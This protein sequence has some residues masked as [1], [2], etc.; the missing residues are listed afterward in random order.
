MGIPPEMWDSMREA[1]VVE[2]WAEHE[3]SVAV[4]VAMGT[5]WRVAMS[6]PTGLDY[7]A[8]PAAMDFLGIP[9]GQR[10]EVF[11]NVRIMEAAALA[12]MSN[13]KG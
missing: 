11:E 8:L 13:A 7:S 10:G 6:G 3:P 4:F 9:P 5:Q 2:V 1:Q 12:A